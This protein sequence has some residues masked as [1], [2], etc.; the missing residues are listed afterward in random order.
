[1]G[2]R[3]P[4]PRSTQVHQLLG[5]R[6]STTTIIAPCSIPAIIRQT[7]IVRRVALSR[8]W[9]TAGRGTYPRTC[10]P[11]RCSTKR[12]Y[13]RHAEDESAGSITYAASANPV[14]STDSAIAAGNY[15]TA[16][17]WSRSAWYVWRR[18]WCSSWD[19]NCLG[20]ARS[21]QLDGTTTCPSNHDYARTP[22]SLSTRP[23]IAFFARRQ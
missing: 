14:T 22:R 6:I 15:S 1:M 10:R 23:T 13:Q 19:C 21:S 11:A 20:P 3:G 17:R 5:R 8:S 7:T 4:N 16:V 12:Y 18:C 2:Y 9:G